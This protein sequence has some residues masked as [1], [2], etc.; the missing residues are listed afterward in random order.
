MR[1]DLLRLPAHIGPLGLQAK[2][3]ADQETKGS[4]FQ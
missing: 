2:I 1:G 3:Q 4:T